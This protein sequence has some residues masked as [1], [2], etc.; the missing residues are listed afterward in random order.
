MKPWWEIF[1]EP[2]LGASIFSIVWFI[3]FLSQSGS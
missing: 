3:G 1:G 2:V